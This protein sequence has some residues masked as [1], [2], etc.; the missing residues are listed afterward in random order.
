M[1]I[2]TIAM[3][4]SALESNQLKADKNS[5]GKFIVDMIQVY[6]ESFEK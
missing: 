3:T 1:E 5:I 4:K 2:F 6:K